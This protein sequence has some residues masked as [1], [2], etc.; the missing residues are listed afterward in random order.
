MFPEARA[1]QYWPKR[2]RAY[3]PCSG[4]VREL[5]RR[6]GR[7]KADSRNRTTMIA[8]IGEGRH[9]R[10]IQFTPR[11]NSPDVIRYDCVALTC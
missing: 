9:V 5:P 7:L 3:L 4:W 6:C 2:R 10:A 1:L 11:P 8:S